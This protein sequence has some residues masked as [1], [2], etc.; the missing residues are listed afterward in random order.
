MPVVLWVSRH[1]PLPAQLKA[2]R[3]RLGDAKVVTVS[4]VTSAEQVIADAEAVGASVLVPVLPLTMIAKIVEYAKQHGITVLYAKMRLAM[5]CNK[6]DPACRDFAA[7][8][9]ERRTLVEYKDCDRVYEFE[10]FEKIVRVDVV[11][12]PW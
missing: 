4:A 11:T 8:D 5:Q 9:P 7:R 1:P 3:E 6:G 10:R 2:L 12:E